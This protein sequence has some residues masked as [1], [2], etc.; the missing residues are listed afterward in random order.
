MKT[1]RIKT[2][3]LFLSMIP[4]IGIYA[5]SIYYVSP[6]AS[7]GGDGSQ[8]APFH[9]IHEAVEKARKDQNSTTIYLREGKYVLDKPLMLTSDDGNDSKELIIK[10]YPGEKTVL[11]SGIV[12][13]LKWE[14]YKNGIMRAVVKESPVMDMLFVNGEL[15][16]MARYP[17]YD[18]KAVRFNGTSALA[19][20]PERV[21]NG[22]ARKGD[23]FM[24][25][26]NMIGV[27]FIIVLQAKMKRESYS[28]K[29]VGR[30]TVLW[31]SIMKTGWW[32][33]SLKNWMLRE[34]GTMIKKKAGC[35]TILYL[36]KK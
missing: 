26:I 12:L 3:L 6:H 36:M 35:I 19:T 33:I 5:Q 15:K 2:L 23:T 18:E 10:N 29:V 22:N 14:K 11:S 28:W 27:I 25:C 30:I 32:R 8:S 31:E 1:Q 21:K 4:F 34:N 20:A 24:P 13:D 7:S 17:N 16:S 9:S